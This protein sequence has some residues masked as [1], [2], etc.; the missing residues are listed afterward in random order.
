MC[1]MDVEVI[2]SAFNDF[3]SE[4]FVDAKDKLTGQIKIAKNDFIKNKLG[5]NG[6]VYN[7]PVTS[8]SPNDD[9]AE[10]DIVDEPERKPRK[11]LKKK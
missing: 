2:K 8:L 6:N 7:L 10:D 11:L 9:N 1:P 3:E 4:N 5:L